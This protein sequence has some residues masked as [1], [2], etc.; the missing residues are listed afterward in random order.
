[1]P[2]SQSGN[3]M[4]YMLDGRQYIIVAVG[5]GNYTSEYIAFALPP[6]EVARP[7]DSQR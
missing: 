4:T 6:G 1:M 2:S 3:P 5:G 7:T